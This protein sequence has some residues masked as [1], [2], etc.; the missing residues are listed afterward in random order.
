MHLY[1]LNGPNLVVKMKD[2]RYW[3]SLYSNKRVR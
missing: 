1:L 3:N 2:D